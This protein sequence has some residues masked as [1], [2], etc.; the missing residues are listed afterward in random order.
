MV[1]TTTQVL[2]TMRKWWP[3]GF[4]EMACAIAL[5]ESAGDPMAF[6]GDSSTGDRSYGL[7]QINML[8]KNVAALIDR[9][10]LKGRPETQLLDPDTNAQA[11][12]VL[13]GG[14]S[15]TPAQRIANMRLAW[16]FDR[17]NADG[18]PSP[19]KTRYE[20]HLPAVVLAAASLN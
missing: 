6:N 1:L 19:Y 2:Q 14:A 15:V 11:G 9:E 3:R 13:S 10:V 20:S 16:Y 4:D 12:F 18:S 7:L 8:D 5:R 17:I